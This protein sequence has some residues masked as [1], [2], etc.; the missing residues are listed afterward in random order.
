M[1]YDV[2]AS[3]VLEQVAALGTIESTLVVSRQ[4]R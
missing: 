2:V 1:I 3:R 4:A